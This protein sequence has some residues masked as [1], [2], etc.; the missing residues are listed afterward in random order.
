MRIMYPAYAGLASLTIP[1]KCVF[2]LLNAL[3]ISLGIF[4]F[5]SAFRLTQIRSHDQEHNDRD[6][7]KRNRQFLLVHFARLADKDLVAVFAYP[8]KQ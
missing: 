4:G 1:L 2:I 6:A 7:Q 8:G 3:R 5:V